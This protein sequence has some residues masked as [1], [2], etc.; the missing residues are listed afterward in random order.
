MTNLT[1]LSDAELNRRLAELRY[2]KRVPFTPDYCN[3][4]VDIGPVIEELSENN[5]FVISQEGVAIFPIKYIGH[6]KNADD[7]NPLRAATICAI[8]VL[9]GE[10]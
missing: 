6:V 2:G 8:M 1:K 7:D 5:N 4:W 9:E 3:N 10:K